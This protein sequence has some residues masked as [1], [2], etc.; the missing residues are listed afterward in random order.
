MTHFAIP[1]G[2]SSPMEAELASFLDGATLYDS[3][4]PPGLEFIEQELAFSIVLLAL[5][6]GLDIDQ[7]WSR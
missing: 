6:A 3:F 2:G 7:W 4:T 5:A 1:E